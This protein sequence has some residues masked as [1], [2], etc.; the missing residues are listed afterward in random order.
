MRTGSSRE[1]SFIDALGAG[2]IGPKVSVLCVSRREFSYSCAKSGG[3]GALLGFG[4]LRLF[5]LLCLELSL[6]KRISD[7]LQSR[8]RQH[9][10]I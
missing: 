3:G 5:R 10:H 7:I 8:Q 1:E 9:V 4:A 2:L 6:N